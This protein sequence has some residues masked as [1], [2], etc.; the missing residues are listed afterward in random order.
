MKPISYPERDS[1]PPLEMPARA[2][3]RSGLNWGLILGILF[4]LAFWA[5]LLWIAHTT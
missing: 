1:Y 3:R 2:S 4:C 5:T